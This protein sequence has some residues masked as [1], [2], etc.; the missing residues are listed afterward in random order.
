MSQVLDG[1]SVKPKTI[2]IKIKGA[3]RGLW[4]KQRTLQKHLYWL[5]LET[6]TDAGLALERPSAAF[7]ERYLQPPH[8]NF[9]FT[10]PFFHFI[11]Y[12]VSYILGFKLKIRE[13]E[14][15]IYKKALVVSMLDYFHS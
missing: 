9:A 8:Q 15:N 2:K 3:E 4:Q 6:Q 5:L 11:F 10:P 12:M 14:F 13:F 7:Q 1:H